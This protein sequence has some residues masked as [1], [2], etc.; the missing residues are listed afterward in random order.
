MR[1]ERGEKGIGTNCH[2]PTQGA[3]GHAVE[4]R[5][6]TS[7]CTFRRVLAGFNCTVD[8]SATREK[9]NQE[10]TRSRAFLG[11]SRA[12]RFAQAKTDIRR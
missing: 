8:N 3:S 4:P 1:V 5:K 11:T 2:A 9:A 7:M 12:S 10:G 6:L